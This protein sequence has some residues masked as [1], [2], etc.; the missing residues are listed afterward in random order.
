M[1]TW[2]INIHR[3]LADAFLM[4]AMFFNPFGF[5]ALFALTMRLT[6]SF[7]AADLIFYGIS[8]SFFI[9]Y[10]VFSRKAKSKSKKSDEKIIDIDL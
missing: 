8:I 9:L 1:T 4:L 10:F 3:N 5:D 2:R 7:L 6:G